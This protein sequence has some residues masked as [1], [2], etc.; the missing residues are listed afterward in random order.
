MFRE[1][2]SCWSWRP[3]HLHCTTIQEHPPMLLHVLRLVVWGV[4]DPSLAS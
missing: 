4:A 1:S 2:A 3:S